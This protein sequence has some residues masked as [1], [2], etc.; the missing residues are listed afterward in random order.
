MCVETSLNCRLRSAADPSFEK[1]SGAPKVPEGFTAEAV[2]TNLNHPTAFDFLPDGRILVGEKS[3]LV[4]VFAGDTPHLV[5]DLRKRVSSF[6]LRGLVAVAVD[7]R[8]YDNKFIYVVYAVRRRGAVANSDAP[9]VAALS[10]FRLDGVR[11]SD[12]RVILGAE[13]RRSG[14]C[15]ALPETADCI[16]S[17]IGHIGADIAFAKDGTIFVSTGDGGG[18]TDVEAIAMKAQAVD[19]LGGKI[20]HI[21]RNGKGLRSNPFYDGEPEHNRS[22]VW[23]LGFRN[24]FRLTLSPRTEVPV[25]G[26]VGWTE[27]EEVDV[28]R[29]GENHGWPCFEGV[30]RT[31]KYASTSQCESIYNSGRHFSWPAIV[32]PH[33]QRWVS[34]TGGAF[35]TGRHYP[36]KYRAY[37]YADFV[38]GWIRNARINPRS[39]R[40]V[41]QPSDFA[42]DAGGPVALRVGSDGLLYVLSLNYGAVYRVTYGEPYKPPAK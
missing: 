40:L 13:G 10:R 30:K 14:S 41:R 28:A 37:Y 26:D 21:D 25:V 31:P 33:R 6:R 32:V 42:T 20:L 29:P 11:A 38:H 8:F 36:K 5:L 3:G 39:G 4:R 24:P 7:P 22:K 27:A 35:V 23:A 15:A 12:E 18:R 2:V 17:E 16:P 1:R 34:L 9:T 19:A